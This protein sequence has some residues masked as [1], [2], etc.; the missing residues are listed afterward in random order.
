MVIDDILIYF[1]D[2][3]K[4]GEHLRFVLGR[5]RDQQLYVKFN[6]ISVWLQEVKFLGH[7]FSDASRPVN[8]NKVSDVLNWNTPT[9]VSEIRSFL[10]LTGNY[11]RFT[12][13]L[14]KLK[15]MTELLKKDHKFAGT[16]K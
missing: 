5:L 12:E 16:D 8:P 9:N 7:E 6:K 1:E 13:N 3:E 2:E 4:H 14:Y 10:D 11:R 15:P